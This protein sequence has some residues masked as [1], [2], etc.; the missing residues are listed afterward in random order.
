[1]ISTPLSFTDWRTAA[2]LDSAYKAHQAMNEALS[3]LAMAQEMNC[4]P[5]R[6]AVV[7]AG[8]WIWS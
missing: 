6:S 7:R 1:M 4:R 3:W 2:D 8:K 5:Q